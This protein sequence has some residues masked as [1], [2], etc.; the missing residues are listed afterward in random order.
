MCVCVRERIENEYENLC[1]VSCVCVRERKRHRKG[2]RSRKSACM[3]RTHLEVLGY[4][5]GETDRDREIDRDRDAPLARQVHLMQHCF[6]EEKL[7]DC[8]RHTGFC[9][10]SNMAMIFRILLTRSCN[11]NHK[12][13]CN[14]YL[15][16]AECCTSSELFGYHLKC[17]SCDVWSKLI[18]ADNTSGEWQ[19][20]VG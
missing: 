20:N 3:R 4:R 19:S 10:V 18:V 16:W 9:Q 14:K 17:L 2:Q 1:L 8:K 7:L 15:D 11:T 12:I 6:S 13:D 5:E